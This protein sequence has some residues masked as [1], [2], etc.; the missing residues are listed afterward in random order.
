[1]S[2]KRLLMSKQNFERKHESVSAS[3]IGPGYYL[4]QG[5]S[6]RYFDE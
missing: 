5:R 3:L 4:Y 2:L 6:D 1:M